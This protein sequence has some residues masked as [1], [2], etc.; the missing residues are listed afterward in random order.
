MAVN[1]P[2]EIR[3]V[4]TMGGRLA[5]TLATALLTTSLPLVTG[6]AAEDYPARKIRI[7]VPFGA[8]GP[9]DTAARL[10]GNDLQQSLGKPFVIEDRPGAG[11]V[12]GTAEAAK[13]APD[14]AA[15]RADGNG[16]RRSRV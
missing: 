5:L 2:N 10:L 15:R 4:E 14:G 1:G 16:S 6:S 8:G 12:I 13:S 3:E 11:D 7:I 9:A